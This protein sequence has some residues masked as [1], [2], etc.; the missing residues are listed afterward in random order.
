MQVLKKIE[1]FNITKVQINKKKKIL[2]G[3]E[4]F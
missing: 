3:F 4:M 1:T 2:R